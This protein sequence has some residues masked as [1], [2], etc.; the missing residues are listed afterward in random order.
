MSGDWTYVKEYTVTPDQTMPQI[1]NKCVGAFGGTCGQPIPH[2]KGTTRLTWKTGPLTLSARARYLGK[3]TIDTVV[4]PRGQG[5]SYPALNTLTNPVIP[6]YTYFDLTAA[7]DLGTRTQLTFGIRN[8]FDKDPPVLG[9]SQLPA[10]NT[11]PI[12]Y[13]VAGRLFFLSVDTKF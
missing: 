11:D 5:K 10:D 9:S 6:A 2:W 13:D 1:Q 7:Y 12:A 4:V 3:A 8:V